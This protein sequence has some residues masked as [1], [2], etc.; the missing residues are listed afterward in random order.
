MLGDDGEQRSGFLRTTSLGS[1]AIEK[2]ASL[3]H[4]V[5]R[6]QQKNGPWVWRLGAQENSLPTKCLDVVR[7]ALVDAK[8]TGE[9]S[10]GARVG[11]TPATGAGKAANRRDSAR[12][13]WGPALGTTVDFSCSH[14]QLLTSPARRSRVNSA[15]LP[16]SPLRGLYCPTKDTR[17]SPGSSVHQAGHT[18]SP[19]HAR[20]ITHCAI[21]NLD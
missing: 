8:E 7:P 5:A 21:H 15:T 6:V 16:Q 3:D 20:H 4:I 9:L 19:D 11:G 1:R 14:A 2:G 10:R 17:Q 13:W 12:R 18:D